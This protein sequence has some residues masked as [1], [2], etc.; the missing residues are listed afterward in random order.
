MTENQR[1]PKIEVLSTR[2]VGQR[3]RRGTLPEYSDGGYVRCAR[4][5]NVAMEGQ[6]ESLRFWQKGSKISCVKCGK[7]QHALA[8][9]PALGIA[10]DCR[11]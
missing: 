10:I 3:I 5:P 8:V 4:H 6:T 7:W 1:K 9:F 2:Q 11:K